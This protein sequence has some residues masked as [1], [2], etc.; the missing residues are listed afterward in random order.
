[1]T[2]CP[3]C[4]QVNPP[5]ARFCN[6]C[7][8]PLGEVPERLEEERKVVTVLFV[9]LVG[10][11]ARAEQLDPEDVRAI[12][13]PYFARIR[14]EIEACG[15]TVEKFIGDA[16]MAVFGA[17]VAHGDDPERAVRAAISIRDAVEELNVADPELRLQVR[18]AVNTG[19]ALVALGARASEGEGM[20][21]G[22]V[23]NTASRLQVAA[24]VGGILVGDETYRSTRSVVHYVEA[25]PVVAKGKREPVRAWRALSAPAPPG[26]RTAGRVPMVGRSSEVVLLKGIWERVVNERRPQLVTVFGPA[27]IGKTRLAAEFGELIAADDARVV[28]GRS[29]PYGEVIPYSAFAAQVKQ[30]AQIFDTDSTDVAATKLNDAVAAR[31]DGDAAELASHI[32]MLIGVGSEG[33]V[34]DRQTLFFS[35]RRLVEAVA[36]ERPTVLVFEDIHWADA[37]MLDLLEVLA[38]RIRDV[39]LLLLALTRP[40][41]L[42]RRPTWGGGL[43]GYTAVPLEP[44][45]D[46]DAEELAERLLLERSEDGL[47]PTEIGAV[48]EGNPLFIE[49]LAA[50]LAEAGGSVAE[51]PTTIRGIVAARIDA[52]PPAERAA[53]LDASVVGKVFWAGALERMSSGHLALADLLD[54]L[55]GRDFIRRE[56]V[57]RLRGQQQFSF[58]HD[59]LRDVA[60]GTLPR[61]ERRKRHAQVAAFL[62]ETTPELPA[63]ASALAHHWQEAGE[64]RR[65]AEYFVLAGDQAGRGWAKEQAVEYYEQ[66]LGLVPEDDRQLRREVAK[67]YAVAAQASQHLVEMLAGRGA[68]RSAESRPE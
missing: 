28:R 43:P 58:K 40:E 66:A 31:L 24:P 67:R 6:A 51:L 33:D 46:E 22:D 21:A 19:E 4:G 54:S 39:P 36:A 41:L 56:P 14:S 8:A 26:E 53:L 35:A 48:A 2:T 38:S 34:G 5:G 17:P 15:G 9:D 18:I 44:L 3:A 64:S 61:A 20:V 25:E 16:V 42:E 57:S 60:Y 32:A 59:L 52:L 29:L 7:A 45:G 37:G 49:E 55:E 1:M 65:A 50:S 23:A 27:G 11:T 68:P 62:E 10:F 63:A 47:D 13:T 12:L 30:L